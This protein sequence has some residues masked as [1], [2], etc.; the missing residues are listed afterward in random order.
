MRH[1]QKLF[2]KERRIAHLDAKAHGTYP[3][4]P[5]YRECLPIRNNEKDKCHE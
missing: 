3:S 5:E 2:V 4:L 1:A